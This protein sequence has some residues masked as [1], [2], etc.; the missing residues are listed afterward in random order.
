MNA[1]E[2][3]HILGMV[4]PATNVSFVSGTGRLY[5]VNHVYFYADE[6]RMTSEIG[7]VRGQSLTTDCSQRNADE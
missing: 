1:A 5:D 7:S 4:P 2:L 6:V 3:I